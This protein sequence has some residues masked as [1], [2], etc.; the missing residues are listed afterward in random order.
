MV[1]TSVINTPIRGSELEKSVVTSLAPNNPNPELAD[2]LVCGV[3]RD[4]YPSTC[5]YNTQHSHKDI[6]TRHNF[7]V[8]ILFKMSAL[9]S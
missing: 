2:P 7:E 4:M 1:S 6:Y 8:K 3:C 9:Q 5:T